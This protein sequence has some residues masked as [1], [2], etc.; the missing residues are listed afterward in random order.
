MPI[1]KSD[2]SPD[3]LKDLVLKNALL[4]ASQYG[5][6]ANEKI[7][8][9]KVV[10]GN[11]EFKSNMKEVVSTSKGVVE[12]VNGWD[13]EKQKAEMDRLGLKVEKKH[14][15]EREGGLPELPKAKYGKV[16]MRMAPYPSG[17]LHIGNTRM[18]ILND[19]YKKR[20][21][22]TLILCFDDTIGSKEKFV[23]KEAYDLIKDGLDWLGVKYDKAIYKSDRM[24]IFYRYAEDIL[25]R[26]LAYVCLCE[27]EQLRK[28]RADGV[29]C[30]H[31]EQSID[32]NLELWNGM[33]SGKFKGGQA[34]VRLKTDVNHPNPAF[35]DRVLLRVSDSEHPR[36][37]SKYKVW[38][39]LEFSW[40]VDDYELGMT[41]ILRGKDLVMEDDM[42]VYVWEKL[43][44]PKERM[45]IFLH[46]GMLKLDEVKLSKSA[47]RAS[48]ESGEFTGWDDP[49]T[50]SLQSLRKR[51]IMPEAVRNFIIKMGMS[52]ADVTVPA[53]IL[54]SENRK[55]IDPIAKRYFALFEPVKFSVDGLPDHDI[56]KNVKVPSH[57]EFP[58]MGQRSVPF[59]KESV[60]IERADLEKNKGKSV[61]LIN[62][63]SAKLPSQSGKNA[64]YESDTIGMNMPK[65]Q[66][67][68]EPNVKIR[69]VMPDGTEK[70]AVAEPGIA[71]AKEGD[72]VQLVRSGFCRVDSAGGKGGD[73]VLYFAHK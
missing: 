16:V 70:T 46:Y 62:L 72:I 3:V 63:F 12:E 15:N 64:K 57:P 23:V 20:Y 45:P 31:R 26:G 29:G 48:I 22:G 19:E 58:E 9:G 4:N 55:I 33:L 52:L 59:D 34:A 2:T 50:W 67:V 28:N 61:G 66:W 68:S 49:R 71:D 24:E 38:P 27:S 37:G 65:M 8:I 39:M 40:A 13:L 36:V 10:S 73:I 69:V 56:L 41:H 11:P 18:V 60:F 17:P 30:A 1:K 32:V 6:K 25:K 44:V 7:V 14:E 35:R 21:G 51:G 42:E 53:E 54:Y 43:G 5:G 47:S